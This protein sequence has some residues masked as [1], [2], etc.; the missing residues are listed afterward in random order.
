M[1]ENLDEKLGQLLRQDA[2]PERDPAFRIALL[3]RRERQ[4]YQHRQRMVL[5][6]GAMLAVLLAVVFTLSRTLGDR[7]WAVL[8]IAT[9]CAALAAASLF[10]VRGVLMVVRHLRGN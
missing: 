3:E 5:A 1:N 2:P 7:M 8:L 9:F 4:R 6:C 10:S